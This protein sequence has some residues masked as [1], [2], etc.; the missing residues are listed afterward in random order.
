MT[1][2]RVGAFVHGREISDATAL[3]DQPV[4]SVLMLAYNHAP[5]IAQAI[6][7]VLEQETEFSFELVIAEDCSTDA[8]RE[9]A[10]KFQREAPE[11]IRVM[12][13]D[14]NV[15]MHAN[16]D[17]AIAAARGEFIAYCEGDDYWI[18]RAKLQKQVEFMR[19]NPTCGL[20]HGNYLNLIEVEGVWRTRLAFRRPRQLECR[21]GR[22]YLA[23]LQ[24]NRIQTCTTLSRRALVLRYRAVGPGVGAYRV[25]DWPEFLYVA[26]EAEIGF[27][28]QPLAAYRRTPGSVTNAGDVAAV[29]R[30]LDAIRMVEDF[31][32]YFGNDDA[33]RICALSAQFQALMRLAFRAGD[34]PRFEQAWDWLSSH[35]PHAL[36]S[37]RARAMRRLI[38]R[39][40]LARFLVGRFFWVESLLHQITFRRAVPAG[41]HEW[42]DTWA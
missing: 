32:E 30:G 14:H 22:I 2:G 41:S 18:D 4:V 10:R 25:G 8:T 39:P 36:R 38:G 11:R 26:H 19:Q 23:L 35:C 7:S 20:V 42:G 6:A 27:I 12:V 17:R 33:T 29:E 15:G 13:S 40:I 1:A 21:A 3:V 24:A 31:C 5:Y 34:R 28:N 9:I 16:H 37:A